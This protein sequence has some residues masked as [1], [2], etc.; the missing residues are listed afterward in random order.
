MASAAG[1]VVAAF[2]VDAAGFR[3][4]SA[5]GVLVGAVG[6]AV[7]L[8]A[9]ASRTFSLSIGLAAAALT[10]GAAV[11][12]SMMTSG[13]PAVV[14]SGVAL[15]VSLCLGLAVVR[16]RTADRLSPRSDAPMEPA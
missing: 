16:A 8:T 1:A 12:G 10:P 7:G 3:Y 4:A 9:Q 15:A 14:L 5:L 6:F 13:G 2:A 11:L